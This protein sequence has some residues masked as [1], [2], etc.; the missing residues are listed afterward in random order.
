MG[1]RDF[2]LEYAEEVNKLYSYINKIDEFEVFQRMVSTLRS[3]NLVFLQNLIGLLSEQSQLRLKEIL[4]SKRVV[5]DAKENCS[6]P[7]RILKV[8]GIKKN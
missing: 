6:V 5:I 8:V 2:E 4:Q 7:R 1:N 3:H